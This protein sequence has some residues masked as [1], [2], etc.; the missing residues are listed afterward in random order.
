MRMLKTW[1]IL[2]SIALFAHPAFA[3]EHQAVSS[4]LK[5]MVAAYGAGNIQ[6]ALE[7]A[8]AVL[9]LDPH[10]AIAHYYMGNCHVKLGQT[11]AAIAEYQTCLKLPDGGQ[12]SQY[13]RQALDVLE[14]SQ[15]T[16]KSSR[17]ESANQPHTDE[18][19]DF[20]LNRINLQATEK[21]AN[22]L[23]Q[24]VD[25]LRR[26]KQ[27]AEQRI[28]RINS[29]VEQQLEEIP[30][31]IWVSTGSHAREKDNPEYISTATTLRTA[32]EKKI[33]GINEEI[34][35]IEKQVT[36]LTLSATSSLDKEKN[37]MQTQLNAGAGTI[38]LTPQGTDLYVHNYV[39]FSGQPE[40][41]APPVEQ[42][43]APEMKKIPGSA[44][45]AIPSRHH[46][47]DK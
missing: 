24:E 21:K 6:V 28:A 38:R 2:L 14:R 15:A 34:A 11:A 1:L 17:T 36:Q 20:N 8:K 31:T 12:I 47:N 26:R 9:V 37:D 10:N 42:L 5:H 22:I 30:K 39:N 16:Q 41:H 40:Y 29:D 3:E 46:Q 27:E 4:E 7:G 45:A 25:M 18:P 43:H 19:Q 33:K 23:S 32:A 13:A 44:P 35:N